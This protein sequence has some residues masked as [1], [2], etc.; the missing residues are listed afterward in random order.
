[1][2]ISA[3]TPAEKYLSIYQAILLL[4][5]SIYTYFVITIDP[6]PLGSE[7]AFYAAESGTFGRHQ[8]PGCN[9]LLQGG[10]A[11]RESMW[12]T[13]M[14][15]LLLISKRNLV[16]SIYL[17]ASFVPCPFP[18]SFSPSVFFPLFVLQLPARSVWLD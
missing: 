14:K 5:C 1:M 2:N 13:G 3:P 17:A 16:S 18:L 10:S 9:E 7:K 4:M 8:G 6:V 11:D 12:S 15:Q